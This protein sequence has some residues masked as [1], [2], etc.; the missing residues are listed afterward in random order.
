MTAAIAFLLPDEPNGFLSNWSAHPIEVDGLRWPT[1]E[2]YF[3]AMKFPDDEA[4]RE[5]IRA[6]AD[7]ERAKAVAYEST[8]L[9]A[10]WDVMRD[11]VML[12]A[13]RAKFTQHEDLRRQLLATGEAELVEV[14]PGDGYWGDGGDG[15]GANRAG[16][17]TMQVRAEMLQCEEET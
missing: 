14:N 16:R 7:P 2:H 13:L 8:A 5:R 15:S 3:Q 10:G 1:V 17:L 12:T 11:Q 9:R 6:E 4:H